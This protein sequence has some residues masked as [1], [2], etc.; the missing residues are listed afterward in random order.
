MTIKE[1]Q[2]GY[3]TSPYFKDLYLYL[4]QDKL[5]SR[6]SAIHKVEN[7]AEKFIML[8]LLL[9]KLIKT[10]KRETALLAVPENAQTKLLHSIILVCLQDIKE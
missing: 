3:L 2:A 10:P 5:P 6:K 1:I 8:D 7:L 9:F 4:A